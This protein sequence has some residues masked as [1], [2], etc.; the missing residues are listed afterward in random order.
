M[1]LSGHGAIIYFI[2]CIDT[3]ANSAEKCCD[4]FLNQRPVIPD[5]LK[6]KYLEVIKE[7][8][9]G[10]TALKHALLCYLEGVCPVE[11]SRQHSR[12]IGLI[13]SKA[14]KMEW[15]ITK[16][17]FSSDLSYS[18]KIH[19][20]LCLESIVNVSDLAEDAAD[21]PELVTLKSMV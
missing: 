11:V 9:G 17:I 21:R 18:H 1:S 20:R 13:E 10:S 16:K 6:P 15:D 4:F 19:L 3:V 2:P 12:E 14:D 7:S 8:L 5:F